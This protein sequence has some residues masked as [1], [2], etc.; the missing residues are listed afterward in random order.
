[1]TNALIFH[2]ADNDSQGNWFPWLTAE[3]EKQG[4]KVWSPD[5]PHSD[6]PVQKD[7]LAT[8]FSNPDWQFNRDSVLIGHSVGA[9]LILRILERLPE[10]VQINKAILVAGVVELGTKPE[11]FQ[12]KRSLVESPFNWTKI[13]KSARKF[14]FIHSD[15]DPYQCGD[16]QGKIMYQHLGGELIIKSGEG[17]FNLE[18]GPQYK[19]FPLI[20]EIL[21]ER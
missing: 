14:Y 2:G 12:Y 3:L 16:D 13:K 4:Y 6:H 19:K 10:D 1:M 21:D 15:N 9:T 11:S 20:L 18:K 17:H 5:L 7:W 8:I